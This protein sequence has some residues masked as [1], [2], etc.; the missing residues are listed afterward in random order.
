MES[1]TDT[2]KNIEQDL[3]S[4]VNIFVRIMLKIYSHVEDMKVNS[5]FFKICIESLLF[6]LKIHCICLPVVALMTLKT[7]GVFI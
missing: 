3:Y 5:S 7:H 6:S 1:Y 4:K 2:K